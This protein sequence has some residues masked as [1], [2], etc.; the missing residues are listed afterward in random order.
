MELEQPQRSRRP[1]AVEGGKSNCARR[2]LFTFNFVCLFST[3][4]FA[5]VH[6]GEFATQR[7]GTVATLRSEA[8]QQPGYGA[9]RVKDGRGRGTRRRR[10]VFPEL[11]ATLRCVSQG[12]FS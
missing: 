3:I 10:S 2:A 4:L 7:A 12:E 5:P 6:G 1:V 8:A 9:A 11:A